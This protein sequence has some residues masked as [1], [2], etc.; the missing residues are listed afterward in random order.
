MIN[1]FEIQGENLVPTPSVLAISFF[2]DIWE[3]DKTK[4]KVRAMK[5]FRYI[6]LMLHPKSIFIGYTEDERGPKV[7]KNVFENEEWKPDRK[8]K[9]AMDFFKTEREKASPTFDLWES[10]MVAARSLGKF[11][12]GIDF[13]ERDENGRLIHSV[14]QVTKAMREADDMASTIASLYEK[15]TTEQYDSA[16]ARAGRDINQ[17]EK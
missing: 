17:F 15:V 13:N 10:T 16:K 12:R 14:S 9:K 6:Y 3:R 1:I 2:K 5:E 8:V 11:L 7:A 4:K